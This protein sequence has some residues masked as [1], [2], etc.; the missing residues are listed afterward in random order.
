MYYS[1]TSHAF[2]RSYSIIY[3]VL[4]YTFVLFLCWLIANTFISYLYFSYH[5]NFY[6]IFHI[7]HR[8][9]RLTLLLSYHILSYVFTYAFMCFHILY[10]SYTFL[11]Y[12]L[13]ILF[14]YYTL[15]FLYTLFMYCSFHI[16]SSC[17]LLLVLVT[18]Y[19]FIA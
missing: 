5:V 15:Y 4:S 6:L 17:T 16:L 2:V 12:L 14:V 8:S 19:T 3:L 13:S 1:Y 11:F 7:S 9:I 10:F 18:V